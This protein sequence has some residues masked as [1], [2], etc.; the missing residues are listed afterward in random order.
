MLGPGEDLLF[1]VKYSDGSQNPLLG[2]KQ[3]KCWQGKIRTSSVDWLK[4][5]A[6]KLSR[7]TLCFKHKR[8]KRVARVVTTISSHCRKLFT[9]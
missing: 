7:V 1:R 4:W 5:N 6:G 3:Q 2:D 9:P 8:V